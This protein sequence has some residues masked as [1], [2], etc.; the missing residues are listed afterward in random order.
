MTSLD[1]VSI[2]CTLPVVAHAV[3]KA[4]L[5]EDK[6]KKEEDLPTTESTTGKR[7]FK[8][9]TFIFMVK[10]SGLSLQLL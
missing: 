9:F 4:H 2:I 10:F 8:L 1:A 3:K 5:S 6:G 7:E